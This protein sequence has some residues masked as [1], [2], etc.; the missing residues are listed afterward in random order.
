MK[1]SAFAVYRRIRLVIGWYGAAYDFYRRKKNSY[2]EPE[3]DEVF[4]QRL[5]GIYHSTARDFVE[6]VNN[7]G[8][9]VKSKINK[10]ILC[11]KDIK[12][13]LQQ[14][15]SVMIHGSDYHVTAVEPVLYSDEVIA[16]EVSVEEFVEGV[17]Q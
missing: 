12:P 8:T 15:D 2:G 10:G 9:S 6:L 14:G 17:D 11:G 5:D 1:M 16:Y 13:A 4:V 3:G 7:E